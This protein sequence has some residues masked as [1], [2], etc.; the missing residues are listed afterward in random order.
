MSRYLAPVIVLV[1]AVAF[2]FFL[3]NSS[4]DLAHEAERLSE[5]CSQADDPSH[6]YEVEV[7]NLYPERST[8]EIFGII[9]M[10]RKLDP[11][12]Q[13]CH[14]LSH[15]LGERVVAEDPAQ[16]VDA[17]P[18]N[19]PD[20]LCSNGFIHGVIGGR[21]R[22][23]VLDDATLEK[24][25]PDFSRACEPREEWKPSALDQAICYHGVGHLYVFITDA[26][27]PKALS[28]CERTAKGKN[29]QQDFRRVCREGVF[30]QINQALEPDDFLLI[31][32][33]AIKPTKETV[34]SFC[35]RFERDEY[36]GA[37]L[38]ESW[39]FFREELMEGTGIEPFCS[40]HPN[41]REETACYEAVF[42]ILGRQ[43]LN[44]EDSIIRAC[45]EVPANRRSMCYEYG[46]QAIL[47]EDR[48]NGEGAIAFCERTPEIYKNSCLNSLARKTRFIFGDLEQMRKF[49]ALL[50][51]EAREVCSTQ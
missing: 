37:C 26:D 12:Y 27:L 7:P 25:I 11:N 40:G 48:V 43:S 49:C 28:L 44:M 3:T 39:P 13:F 34:R 10:I 45:A 35:A 38:R 6:C 33:M 51:K 23:E 21:F 9:R 24:F 47:E 41:A 42:S 1:V 4:S 22:A 17:I 16:W 15:L 32:R 50:P 8:G 2:L 31:E 18:L 5:E 14:V 20:G 29:P 36:E 46:A 30:M 19:P